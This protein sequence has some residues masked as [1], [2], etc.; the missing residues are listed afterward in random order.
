MGRF[1]KRYIWN[2]F[3]VIIQFPAFRLK[4]YENETKVSENDTKVVDFVIGVAEL[5]VRFGKLDSRN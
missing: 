1:Q 5:C 4:S 3:D 2:K